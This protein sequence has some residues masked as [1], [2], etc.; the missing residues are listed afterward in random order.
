VSKP[1]TKIFLC[2]QV[3]IHEFFE[4]VNYAGEVLAFNMDTASSLLRGEL[5]ALF[6]GVGKCPP[7]HIA[8]S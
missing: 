8:T 5:Q 7:G 1:A 2:S 6:R 4:F 3:L